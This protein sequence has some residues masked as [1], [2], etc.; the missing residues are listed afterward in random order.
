MEALVLRITEIRQH[1]TVA[2]DMMEISVKLTCPS[3][4]Q[5]PVS[6]EALALKVLVL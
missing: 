4:Y 2:K 1:A 6:M 3:A 5:T